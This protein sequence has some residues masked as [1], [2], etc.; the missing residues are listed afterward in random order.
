M[1]REKF[2]RYFTLVIFGTLAWMCLVFLTLDT[3]DTIK[4]HHKV[5]QRSQ[6]TSTIV[7]YPMPVENAVGTQEIIPI[8]KP[9]KEKPIHSSPAWLISDK[10]TKKLE[11]MAEFIE[12]NCPKDPD[13]APYYRQAYRL[14][15]ALIKQS[16]IAHKMRKSLWGD[17]L[18]DSLGLGQDSAFVY[19]KG[20]AIKANRRYYFFHN[21]TIEHFPDWRK[22]EK[23]V[24]KLGDDGFWYPTMAADTSKIVPL[25]YWGKIN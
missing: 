9:A 20:L 14:R 17:L 21:A 16:R 2:Q 8:A 6:D 13:I 10:F 18:A 1:K 11:N 25:T 5:F 23:V 22:S 15:V 24:A 19:S 4:Y 7:N 12:S 3:Y